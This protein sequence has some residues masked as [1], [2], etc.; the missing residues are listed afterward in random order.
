MRQI[1]LLTDLAVLAPIHIH[2]ILTYHPNL[3]TPANHRL[4][5]LDHHPSPTNCLEE[6]HRIHI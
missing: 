3:L 4:D 2:Y 6:L 1:Y 5:R